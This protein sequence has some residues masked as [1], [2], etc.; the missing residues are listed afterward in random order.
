MSRISI[1]RNAI[2]R[3]QWRVSST[4]LILILAAWFGFVLNLGFW[5]FIVQRID[6]SNAAML[7]FSISLPVFVFVVFVWIFGL[8]LVKPFAKPLIVLLL[9]LSSAANY[10]MFTLGIQIDSSMMRNLFETNAREAGDF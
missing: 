5:R 7:G 8:L 6:I 10:G 4:C 2:S 9:L 3:R 1:L